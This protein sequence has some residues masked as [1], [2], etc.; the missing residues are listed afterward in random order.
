M[1]KLIGVVTA[2]LILNACDTGNANAIPEIEKVLEMQV[3]EWN[4]GNIEG[5]MQGYWNNDSLLFI[6]KRGPKYGY[7]TTLANYKKGYPDTQAMG[8]LSFSGLRFTKL[9]TDCY[10]VMGAWAL[11]REA[12]APGG[13]FTLIF[14]KI[15]GKWVIISDHT[16]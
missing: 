9:A 12:D 4:N 7:A 6:G 2:L 14:K 15:D 1:R 3:T 16:S 10:Q 11:Q 13:Y 8:M 5:Y